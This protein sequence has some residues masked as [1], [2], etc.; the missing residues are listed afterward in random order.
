MRDPRG[1]LS[2][3]AKK[4][5][6]LEII[7]RSGTVAAVIDLLR[8]PEKPSFP[9]RESSGWQPAA[10]SFTVTATLQVEDEL[11]NQTNVTASWN[12]HQGP[13]TRIGLLRYYNPVF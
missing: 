8:E 4:S 13:E 3:E 10:V 12:G 5:K 1:R 2:R 7:R 11:G 9:S 6:E